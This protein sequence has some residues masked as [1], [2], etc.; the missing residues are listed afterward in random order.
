FSVDSHRRSSA[1]TFESS[2]HPGHV[3]R[4]LEEQRQRDVLCDVTVVTA[5]GQ[6][7]RAH[8]S[9]LASCS[10]YFS[11]RVSSMC[12]QNAVITLP[13]EVRLFCLHLQT[14]FCK[15]NVFD[16]QA[17]VSALGF[18]DL[19]G[20]C[21]DFLLP[22]FFSSTKPSAVRPLCCKKKCKKSL[23]RDVSDSDEVLL[24]DKEVKPV[25]ESP[26]QEEVAFE[27]SNSDIIKT[28]NNVS[29]ND[30]VTQCPKYRKF[31]MACGKEID[32]SQP[33][34]VIKYY[35]NSPC[36]SNSESGSCPLVSRQVEDLF[37]SRRG[38]FHPVDANKKEK[39]CE[40]K[41]QIE[42]Q[43]NS[44][45]T[46]NVKKIDETEEEIIDRPERSRLQSNINNCNGNWTSD[47]PKMTNSCPV[48]L[49]A[50]LG[51]SL[52]DQSTSVWQYP[53]SSEYEGTSQSGLSSVNSG[54]DSDTEETAAY[55]EAYA[56][57]RARQVQLPFPVDQIV[58]MSRNNFQELL[59][60]QSLTQEQLEL[61]RDM[62]RRSKNRL[63][64]KR[65]RKRKLDCIY[66]LQCEINKLKTEREMLIQE[67]SRLSQLRLK[68]CN[69]VSA[70]CQRVCSSANLPPEQLQQLAKYTAA[71]CPLTSYMPLIDSLLSSQ[72]KQST[73]LFPSGGKDDIGCSNTDTTQEPTHNGNSTA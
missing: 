47:E 17:S 40:K 12:I 20:A 15:E 67:R 64:A 2:L 41:Q 50:Q 27:C 38:N 26:Y 72:H 19:D 53:K 68:T 55:C 51:S 69:S 36:S 16:I 22:K 62:R 56:R 58:E 66:N 29:K 45:S 48:W 35:C 1:F 49:N 5:E 44:D 24:D 70:L 61:V 10:E 13:L 6:S 14:L 30:K 8:R 23:P 57:E 7:F 43:V 3:L 46:C 31:Q 21:F 11:Q 37:D 59:D 71:E 34:P 54:D 25:A 9:V 18:K 60:K 52:Q 39:L 32:K 42:L 65:C 33:K 73:Q 63:A 4:S 28:L